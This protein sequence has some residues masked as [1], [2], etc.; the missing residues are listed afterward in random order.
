[1][2]INNSITIFDL[3]KIANFHLIIL[4]L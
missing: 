2:N 3:L 1:M 4:A